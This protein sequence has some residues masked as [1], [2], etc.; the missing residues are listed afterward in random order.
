[1]TSRPI[2]DGDEYFTNIIF[3]SA[4]TAPCRSSAW[5]TGSR[6]KTAPTTMM[7]RSDILGLL[8][9]YI[10]TRHIASSDGSIDI[11]IMVDIRVVDHKRCNSYIHVW[12]RM[13][14]FAV[15]MGASIF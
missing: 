7:T 6:P 10:S 14:C 15:W 3:D 12:F 8:A 1:M 13:F 4:V 11:C 2:V 5:S 9:H